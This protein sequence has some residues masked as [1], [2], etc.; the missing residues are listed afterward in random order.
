MI[1]FKPFTAALLWII[2]LLAFA[3]FGLK[4]SY[5]KQYTH[6]V[7]S[8]PEPP[9]EITPGGE[10]ASGWHLNQSI[11]WKQLYNVSAE[12]EASTFC[13]NVLMSNYGDRK[14]SGEFSLALQTRDRS[15]E[16]IIKADSI[17]DNLTHQ[18]CFDKFVLGDIKHEPTSLI[19]KG[20]NSPSG[21]AVTAWQ[22]KDNHYGNA[23]IN[24]VDS[25]TS[26]VFSIETIRKSNKKRISAIILTLLCGLGG[27]LLFW[28]RL[29]QSNTE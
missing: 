5:T 21:H 9:P 28:P 3:Q 24:D 29:R 8:Y 6:T 15:Q 22:T 7:L 18:V 12:D 10:I 11:N 16:S 19:I 14:N 25:G 1:F 23:V 17:R 26:L 20:I 2:I 4:D 13:V 27:I